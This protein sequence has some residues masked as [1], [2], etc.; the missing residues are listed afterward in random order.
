MASTPFGAFAR[1]G[2]W[3][4]AERA[5]PLKRDVYAFKQPS[6]LAALRALWSLKARLVDEPAP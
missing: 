2:Q 1:R 4:R 5:A 6:E 3:G